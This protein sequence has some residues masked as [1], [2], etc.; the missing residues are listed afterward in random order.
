MGEKHVPGSDGTAPTAA[1]GFDL[2]QQLAGNGSDA[3][4]LVTRRQGRQLH[5]LAK[6]RGKLRENIVRLKKKAVYSKADLERCP[7]EFRQ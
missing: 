2:A 4:R 5:E 3:E 1:R 7:C 6:Q